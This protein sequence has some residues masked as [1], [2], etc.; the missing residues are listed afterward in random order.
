MKMS[1]HNCSV[2]MS[3]HEHTGDID[4]ESEGSA[5]SGIAE[6]AGRGTSDGPASGRGVAA[7]RAAGAA[8]APAIRA[9]GGP[10]RGAPGAGPPV[11]TPA[12]RPG[13]PAGGGA[14]Q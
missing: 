10:R 6:G 1:A 5:T 3:A 13:A 2:K 9:G 12:C 14:A 11:A 4:D 8:P 7:E